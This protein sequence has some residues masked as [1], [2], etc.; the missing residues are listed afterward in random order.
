[1][2]LMQMS[3]YGAVM[4]LAILIIR[5]PTMN[6]LPKKVFVLLWK[7]AL[8]R[9]LIPYSI[10]SVFSVYS[11]VRRNTPVSVR[12]SL[13]E[14]PLGNMIPQTAAMQM[15]VNADTITPVVQTV[16]NEAA[17]VSIWTVLWAVGLVLCVTFFV[18]SYLRCYSEFRA[19]LPVHNSFTDEWLNEHRLKRNIQIRHSDRIS[20]PLTYGI[21]KPVILMPGRTDW[22]NIQQLEYVLLHEY[23]H[24]CCF[25][26]AWKLIAVLALCI[27]WFNPLVW[28]MYILFN[29]D[30]ELSCDESVVRQFGETSK[31]TYARTLISMEEKK[32]GLTP[33]CNNFSK[34]AIEERIT[35][36]MK[37][38]KV[39]IWAI[40]ISAV[41]LI[42]IVVL[43]AT[44]A[45]KES[46]STA[47]DEEIAIEETVS[48]DTVAEETDIPDVILIEAPAVVLDAASQYV[49][50]DYINMR[51][52][53]YDYS[54]WRIES[55]KHVY[56]YDDFEKMTLQVYQMNYE[57]L[58]D[59]PE[60]VQLV[61]G[62]SIDE[63]G[64]V[65]PGY[66]NS[67]Y[68]IFRQE[69]EELSYL[70]ALGENDCFPGDETFTRDLTY[71]LE[72]LSARNEN[73]DTMMI[74]YAL[75]E[76]EEMPASR[77]VGDGF[78]I[79][80]P[81]MGWNVYK[82][83]DSP[84]E[85]EAVYDSEIRIWVE[86]YT[87]ASFLEVEERLLSEGYAYDDNVV[88]L[89][90]FD[91]P[92]LLE[93]R[94]VAQDNDVWVISSSFN[95]AYEW[96]SRLD[97]IAATFTIIKNVDE[98]SFDADQAVIVQRSEDMREL[99]EIMIVFGEAYFA[100]DEDTI[101]QYLVKSLQDQKITIFDVGEPEI[102]GIKVNS[103]IDGKWLL[104][105][106]F[107]EPEEDSLTYLEVNFIKEDG[108]WK[109]S[110]YG[111]GK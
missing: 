55:L 37:T 109:V 90:K 76:N 56:T 59:N 72:N 9:L 29:R 13:E 58:A 89:Q 103:N 84:V 63:E 7:L 40:I 92:F 44:S 65:V 73:M 53:G 46:A 81:D 27:H 79:Y 69:G 3:F 88:K 80:I 68:F 110:W 96:G 74:S 97:A 62:M 4:I 33:L 54:D 91:G 22:E 6:R 101:R 41:V 23:M 45:K 39:T 31:A 64:W 77:Y 99:E 17:P 82:P 104:S 108:D 28:V 48:E 105:L 60:K 38:K 67:T 93:A 26:M 30:I 52:R 16:Q 32:S 111:L 95:A 49:E 15:N 100:G 5:F 106:E 8:L 71:A 11:L 87:D 42:G 24:I 36:I 25:D 2:S 86:H 107:R 34:N 47:D 98:T 66:P 102:R 50:R 10:P 19:S 78:C 51:N 83:W 61:G 14:I 43:F 35:A 75:E 20:A 18:I 21:L 94:I 70:T 57:F 1:M 12:D 85:M